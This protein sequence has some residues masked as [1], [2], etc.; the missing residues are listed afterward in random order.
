MVMSSRPPKRPPGA[1]TVPLRPISTLATLQRTQHPFGP[2]TLSQQPLSDLFSTGIQLRPPIRS[3]LNTSTP[4]FSPGQPKV[5]SKPA[6]SNSAPSPRLLPGKPTD[7]SSTSVAQMPTPVSDSAASTRM[8]PKRRLKRGRPPG[9][10]K[11]LRVDTAQSEYHHEASKS[12]AAP[13]NPPLSGKRLTGSTKAATAAAPEQTYSDEDNDK[14]SSRSNLRASSRAKISK[15]PESPLSEG[16]PEP[17]TPLES[18]ED[19]PASSARTS[20]RRR[21]TFSP[22][23]SDETTDYEE[24]LDY[25]ETPDYD[26]SCYNDES[27]DYDEDRA[28]QQP[29]SA[30]PSLVVNGF[31]CSIDPITGVPTASMFDIYHVPPQLQGVRVALGTADWAEY[32]EL[33]EDLDRGIINEDAVDRRER[34][35]F[36][37]LNESTRMSIR[38]SMRTMVTNP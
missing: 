6:S 4:Y 21:K 14:P 34:R 31:L 37:A 19:V 20:R 27:R 1:K 38:K 9:R 22:I 10:G 2:M 11:R 12:F 23:D 7:Q 30:T 5:L 15:R 24:T 8:A 26:E 28:S 36:H 13:Y 18:T 32:V 3:D 17:D 25:E 33:I 16:T 35:L 29:Q